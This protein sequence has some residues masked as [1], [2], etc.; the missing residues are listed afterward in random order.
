MLRYSNG[1]GVF[2]HGKAGCL[3]ANPAERCSAAGQGHPGPRGSG[4]PSLKLAEA[5]RFSVI[6]IARAVLKHAQPAPLSPV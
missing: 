5:W 1:T 6:L 4:W 3:D 2:L